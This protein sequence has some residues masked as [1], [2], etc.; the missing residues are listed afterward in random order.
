M[1]FTINRFPNAVAFAS[2]EALL[3]MAKAGATAASKVHASVTS[4][5]GGDFQRPTA[6]AEAIANPNASNL[7]TSIALVN[8]IK[9]V[10]NRT[11]SDD[12]AHKVTSTLISTA[13]ATDLATGITL[14]NALKAAY[15]THRASTTHHY[16]ADA[17]NTITAD[18]ATD[19]S[20]LNTLLNE[21]KTDINAHILLAYTTYLPRFAT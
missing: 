2:V 16:T 12:G 7:A 18:D 21:L 10:Y 6:T 20:S 17:T 4:K 15:E 8:E 14:G 11:L 13:D 19:Q 3:R 1:S 5:P 9:A